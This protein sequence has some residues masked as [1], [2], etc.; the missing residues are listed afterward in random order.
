MTEVTVANA[1]PRRRVPGVALGRLL[2]TVLT[3]EH[4]TDAKLSLVLIDRHRCRRLNERFLGHRY[5]TD[6][7][8]FPMEPLPTL[9]GE[10][11]VNLDRASTQAR[12]FAVPFA[13]EVARLAVHGTLHL[14]GYDDHRPAQVRRMRTAEDRYLARARRAGIVS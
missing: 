4:V 11:Y 13:N 12:R 10:V 9:E 3:G 5:E 7:I 14:L 1:H 6:V 2:R 8:S